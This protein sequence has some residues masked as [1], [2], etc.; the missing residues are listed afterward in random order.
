MKLRIVVLSLSMFLLIAAAPAS[1]EPSTPQPKAGWTFQGC[2]SY[3]GN[4]PCYDVYTHNG[5][6]WICR[7]CGTTGTPNEQKCRRLS[8]YELSN[9]RWC[10]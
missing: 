3:T 1:Q 5:A 6:Y 8:A 4:L 7:T 2:F 10:S 9:G